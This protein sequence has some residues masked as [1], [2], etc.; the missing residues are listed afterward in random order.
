MTMLKL[1]SVRRTERILE[2]YTP[3]IETVS[4]RYGL[5]AAWIK[6]VLRKEIAE[7]DLLDPVADLL[8]RLNWALARL[9]LPHGSRRSILNKRDSSVGY[10]QIF[11]YVAI[12]AANYALDR[13]LDDAA[14]L[15]LPE[16]RR[17]D[18][19]NGD[20]LRAM[21]RRLSQDRKYNIQMAALNLISA[22]EETNGHADFARYTPEEMQR[23]LTRYNA[24]TRQIT[25]YGREVYGYCR[26]YEESA[27]RAEAA[28]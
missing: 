25:A 22:A 27:E 24:N 13:G 14:G 17:P 2:E 6:A 20:D 19:K 9:R 15:K 7:I 10:A 23:A 8:V 18:G 11:A 3:W 4:R 16:G 26:M 21:W 1:Y 12:D 5:S 28:P